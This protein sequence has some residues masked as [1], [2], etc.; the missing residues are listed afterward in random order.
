[1]VSLNISKLIK[2]EKGKEDSKEKFGEKTLGVFF[3]DLSNL[4]LRIE[5]GNLSY[6]DLA[7]GKEISIKGF[8]ASLNKDSFG[9]KIPLEGSFPISGSME[10]LRFDGSVK[11]NGT[12]LISNSKKEKSPSIDLALMIDCHRFIF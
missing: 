7:T 12:F 2:K 3:P 9:N 6:A 5:D 8:T 1:M 4:S 10:D 11:V